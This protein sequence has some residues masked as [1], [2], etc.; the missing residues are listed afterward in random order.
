MR[1]DGQLISIVEAPLSIPRKDIFDCAI[2]DH[3]LSNYICEF[4][5]VLEKQNIEVFARKGNILATSN[6]YYSAMYTDDIRN[7][8]GGIDNPTPF[9]GK[10]GRMKVD[11]I[12]EDGRKVVRDLADL[13]AMAFCQNP[14]KYTKTWFIDGNPENCSADNIFFCSKFD[15]LVFKTFKIKTNARISGVADK[16]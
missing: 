11:I 14:K 4:R 6:G 1:K 5:K 9:K 15:Y 7:K 3:T 16:G 12:A 2:N 13:V 10:D 8:E